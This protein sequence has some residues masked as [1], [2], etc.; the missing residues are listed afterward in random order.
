MPPRPR[1]VAVGLTPAALAAPA[2]AVAV[3][4]VD[5][6]KR[7]KRRREAQRREKLRQAAAHQ[8]NSK[9]HQ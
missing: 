2:S 9:T 1:A 4:G 7:K 6:A 8:Q 5:E 3:Q